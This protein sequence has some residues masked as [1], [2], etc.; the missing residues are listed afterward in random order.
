[1]QFSIVISVVLAAIWCV[2]TWRII[3]RSTLSVKGWAAEGGYELTRCEFALRLPLQAALLS[4][5]RRSLGG[6]YCTVK[7]RDSTGLIREASVRCGAFVGGVFS[8]ER[9]EVTWNDKS[10]A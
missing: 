1:M 8:C 2:W 3:K 5:W 9:I 6:V 10:A 4:L 7:L